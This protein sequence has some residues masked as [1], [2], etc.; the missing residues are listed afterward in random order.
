MSGEEK[1]AATKS[2]KTLVELQSTYGVK[3]PSEHAKRQVGD[4]DKT[5]KKSKAKKKFMQEQVSQWLHSTL[6]H[7]S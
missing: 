4:L 7:T 6:P 2:R 3:D 5:A 1:N